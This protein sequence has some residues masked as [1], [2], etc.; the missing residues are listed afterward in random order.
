MSSIVLAL[1]SAFNVSALSYQ[2]KNGAEAYGGECQQKCVKLVNQYMTTSDRGKLTKAERQKYQY[3]QSTYDLTIDGFVRSITTQC[4]NQCI[5]RISKT[6]C[7]LRD[8]NITDRG[9]I[10]HFSKPVYA[11]CIVDS[12]RVRADLKFLN[13]SQSTS[14]TVEEPYISFRLQKNIQTIV[15]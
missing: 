4:T 5:R 6:Y 8:G 12:V 11:D 10:I 14:K 9:T 7:T 1:G 15:R 3:V 2:Y 13:E